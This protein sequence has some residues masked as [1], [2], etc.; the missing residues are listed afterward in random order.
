MSAFTRECNRNIDTPFDASEVVASLRLLERRM[1]ARVVDEAGALPPRSGH[2]VDLRLPDDGGGNVQ[3]VCNFI[4]RFARWMH[5]PPN[6]TAFVSPIEFL[7][8]IR[9]SLRHH[10]D[11]DP[12]PSDDDEQYNAMYFDAVGADTF[13][14]MDESE[15]IVG[16]P[17]DE[18]PRDDVC[19]REARRYA[20][21]KSYH[22]RRNLELSYNRR[23]ISKTCHRMANRSV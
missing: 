22:L 20:R 19:Q 11:S 14:D 17:G 12:A 1:R 6:H 18:L 23:C 3:Q 16:E 2:K 21:K 13:E 10:G 7:D 9:D 15:F 5:L 4:R 8:V